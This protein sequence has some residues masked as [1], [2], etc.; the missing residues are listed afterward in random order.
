MQSDAYTFVPVSYRTKAN[1][2]TPADGFMPWYNGPTLMQA[3]N[4]LKITQHPVDH[5][6]RLTVHGVYKIKGVGV[7][8]AGRVETGVLK[9]NDKI[10]IAPGNVVGEVKSIEMNNKRITEVYPGDNVGFNIEGVSAKD[11]RHGCVVG[12]ADHDPPA[13]VLDFIAQISTLQRIILATY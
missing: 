1:F 3:L 6:L 9:V 12:H 10:V 13:E 5:P 8:A 7:V 4:E 11:L 2:D